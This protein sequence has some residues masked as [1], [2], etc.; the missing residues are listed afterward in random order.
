M[1]VTPL[2]LHSPKAVRDALSAGGWDEGLAANAATGS[3]P[4]AFHLTDLDQQALEALVHF[5]GT[6][7]LDVLTGDTWAILAG[8]RSRLSAFARPWLV[9]PALAEAASRVGMAMPA[10]LPEVWETARGSIALDAPVIAAI[11]NVTPDSFSDGGNFSEVSA[12][13]AQAETML[14]RGRVNHRRR[15]GVHAPRARGA[16]A[17]GRGASPGRAGDRRAGQGARRSPDLGGYR[18]VGGCPRG[19]GSRG[20]HRQRR[21]GAA[22]RPRHGGHRIGREGRGG[23]DALARNDSRDLILPSRRI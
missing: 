4:L 2:A 19:R 3:H 7:G 18:Q 5:A 1:N 22:T 15:R 20:S 12:A 23:S 21:V 6:L 11:L 14:G 13:L 10:E 16:C 17:G 8:S 9:P